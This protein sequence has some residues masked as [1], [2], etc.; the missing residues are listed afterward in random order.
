[1]EDSKKIKTMLYRQIGGFMD[2]L[3]D[4]KE[5]ESRNPEEV[6]L[7]FTYEVLGPNPIVE[8]EVDL[9]RFYDVDENKKKSNESGTYYVRG[10][11]CT[12][13]EAISKIEQLKENGIIDD[14]TY[15]EK[16]NRVKAL[17]EKGYPYF[18]IQ[19]PGDGKIDYLKVI[20]AK[21]EDQTLEDLRIISKDKI[22]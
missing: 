9:F 14:F 7:V 4:T 17:S 6:D 8:E 11:K 13:E 18:I 10:T 16:I 5:V 12:P 2:G 22:K 19:E 3:S 15:T 1:M 20:E 21:E